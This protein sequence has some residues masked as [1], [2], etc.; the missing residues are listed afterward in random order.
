M[1]NSIKK[2]IN[3]E[4]FENYLFFIINGKISEIKMLLDNNSKNFSS[5]AIDDLKELSWLLNI[6][7]NKNNFYNIL[8]SKL[9]KQVLIQ[10]SKNSFKKNNKQIINNSYNKKDLSNLLINKFDKSFLLNKKISL[11]NNS[12][13]FNLWSIIP[14]WWEPN[15][16]LKNNNIMHWSFKKSKKVNSLTLLLKKSSKYYYF[17]NNY[18]ND[19]N[20]FLVNNNFSNDKDTFLSSNKINNYNFINNCFKS[21][22]SWNNIL[23]IEYYILISNLTF[24]LLFNCFNL[25]EL[26]TEFVDYLVYYI[27]SNEHFYDFELNKLSLKYYSFKIN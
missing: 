10:N 16:K 13:N 9:L 25:L 17:S 8:G 21:E 5:F 20:Y 2:L 18:N 12:Q 15:L 11:N 14:Y 3:K 6:M 27:L 7:V 1:E 23:I 24:N 19:S 4:D 22:I 26:N